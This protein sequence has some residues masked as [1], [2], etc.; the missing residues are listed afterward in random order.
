VKPTRISLPNVHCA[1]GVTVLGRNLREGT[2][3][4]AIR[5]V[6]IVGNGVVVVEGWVVQLNAEHIVARLRRPA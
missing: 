5:R 4:A 2:G 6:D 3:N 1:E